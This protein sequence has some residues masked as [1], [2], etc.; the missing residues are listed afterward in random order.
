MIIHHKSG[1][2][3]LL[4]LFASAF[5]T[6]AVLLLMA[7]RFDLFR[8]LF[9]AFFIALGVTVVVAWSQRLGR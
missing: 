5:V 7:Y 8:S 1:A 9:Q 2:P 3:E 4:F 6:V